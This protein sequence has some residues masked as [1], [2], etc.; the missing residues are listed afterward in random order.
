MKDFVLTLKM[1]ISTGTSLDVAVDS[2]LTIA[3]TLNCMVESSFN[4]AK[5]RVYP[6]SDVAT[7]CEE[8]Y[9]KMEKINRQRIA[10]DK[11]K[12]EEFTLVKRFEEIL[13]LCEEAEKKFFS[14]RNISEESLKNIPDYTRVTLWNN[15]TEAIGVN[16]TTIKNY[17]TF[18]NMEG[19]K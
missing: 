2:C 13:K 19:N 1:E 17:I 4:S 10:D 3:K 12:C 7:T 9:S 5:F 15:F 14:L 6:T 11:K 18:T 16:I 8:V